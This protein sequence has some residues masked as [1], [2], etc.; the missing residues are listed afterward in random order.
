MQKVTPIE[1]AAY[2][3]GN[4]SRL[5]QAL[6]VTRQAVTKW[7]KRVPAE[8]VLSIEALTGGR[9]TRHELRPDLYPL[10]K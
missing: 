6:G 3:V 2:C 4:K 7:E 1:R 5:A 9:V 10:E 8:R